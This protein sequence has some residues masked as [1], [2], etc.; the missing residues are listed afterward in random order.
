MASDTAS[1]ARI[2]ATWRSAAASA[3]RSFTSAVAACAACLA[4]PKRSRRSGTRPSTSPKWRLGSASRLQSVAATM[5]AARRPF[6]KSACSPKKGVSERARTAP[7]TTGSAGAGASATSTW[8]QPLTSTYIQSAAAPCVTSTAPACACVSSIRPPTSAS[9]RALRSAK[10]GTRPSS[11]ARSS[12]A[13]ASAT[14]FGS[15][16]A[17]RARTVAGSGARAEA[18]RPTP[19]ADAAAS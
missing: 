14:C 13:H 18:S 5:E 19:P 4:R 3:S 6:A 12:S 17:V 15:V 2:S 8:H 7:T 1:R 11:R 16:L 10:M 9:V